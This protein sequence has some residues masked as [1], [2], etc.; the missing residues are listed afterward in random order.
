MQQAAQV[1]A[2]A[3]MSGFQR[4]E[5]GLFFSQGNLGEASA[6]DGIVGTVG[7]LPMGED[8]TGRF[9]QHW[10]RFTLPFERFQSCRILKPQPSSGIFFRK[11]PPSVNLGKTTF[12][13]EPL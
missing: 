1:E 6:T 12:N 5:V 9:G 8:S 7:F 3:D 10:P 11:M 4:F 13:L 2:A